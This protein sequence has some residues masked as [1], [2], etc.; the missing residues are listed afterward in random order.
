MKRILLG[1]VALAFTGIAVTASAQIGLPAGFAQLV[2][3]AG[4][5]PAVCRANLTGG[6]AI[7][8]STGHYT[9]TC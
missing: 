7:A 6:N 1:L 3:S 4:A 2:P 8:V 5:G 9:F